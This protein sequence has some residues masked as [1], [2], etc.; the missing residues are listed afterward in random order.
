MKIAS[1]RWL[2]DLADPVDKPLLSLA[3]L[4]R[5]T[6]PLH[7]LLWGVVLTALAS[8]CAVVWFLVAV[9]DLVSARVQLYGTW[10]ASQ[11]EADLAKLESITFG[12]VLLVGSLVVV[13]LSFCTHARLCR[14]Q[15]R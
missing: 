10:H 15:S 2:A 3:G 9:S 1:T 6:A 13:L 11:S 8:G 5:L 4:V 12:V 14:R 7:K